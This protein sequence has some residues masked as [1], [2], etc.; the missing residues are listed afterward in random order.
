[1][2]NSAAEA[3]GAAKSGKSYE[4]SAQYAGSGLINQGV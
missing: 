1:M 3:A 4:K 2:R